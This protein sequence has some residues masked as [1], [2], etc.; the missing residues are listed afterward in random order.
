MEETKILSFYVRFSLKAIRFFRQTQEPRI[1]KRRRK[2][3]RWRGAREERRKDL[4]KRGK[5][6]PYLPP[7]L[8]SIPSSE[9]LNLPRALTYR[10]G[11]YT[12]TRTHQIGEYTGA[13]FFQ[14]KVISL[15][16]TT[17]R[18]GNARSWELQLRDRLNRNKRLW[19][20][21]SLLPVIR[22]IS[23]SGEVSTDV[24]RDVMLRS[25]PI[26]I[27]RWS[28]SILFEII[29]SSTERNPCYRDDKFPE[30]P[31]EKDSAK[32]SKDG[33]GTLRLI[34]FPTRRKVRERFFFCT[35]C[36]RLELPLRFGKFSLDDR[37]N[38]APLPCRARSHDRERK[39]EDFMARA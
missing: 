30:N 8:L 38:R 22:G 7:S 17:S 13:W 20:T 29:S 18:W 12:H 32:I 37:G 31:R 4:K 34:A 1:E 25:Q 26:L 28:S 9:S 19:Y 6:N 21:F 2:K 27:F 24:I 36:K 10:N 16:I 33:W 14:S 11:V 5:G 23:S 35:E 39:I 15:V 3:E